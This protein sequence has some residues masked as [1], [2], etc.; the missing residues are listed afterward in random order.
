M[1]IRSCLKLLVI[2][3]F[4]FFL[5]V[6]K[7]NNFYPVFA[8]SCSDEVVVDAMTCELSIDYNGEKYCDIKTVQSGVKLKC[9]QSSCKTTA[10]ICSSNDVG[11]C[12]V[13]NGCNAFPCSEASCTPSGGSCPAECRANS[14]GQGYSPSADCG[15]IT[16]QNPNFG[17]KANQACCSANSCPG[18]G[19]GGSGCATKVDCPPGTTRGTEV[20]ENNCVDLAWYCGAGS[21]QVNLGCCKTKEFCVGET[22]W[23]PCPTPANPGKM[24]RQCVEYEERCTADTVVTYAC[25][26]SCTATAPTNNSAEMTSYTTAT[27]TWTAGTGGNNQQLYVGVDSD[28]VVA[29]CPDG[30]LIPPA[31]P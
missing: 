14:C 22:E 3:I 12:T 7:I 28:E 17:C 13:S 29:S 19:G 5:D 11:N 6:G 23:V 20:V 18:G 21:A 9:N 31:L 1:K 16:P 26:P 15:P 24:C 8:Q 25:V 27:I 4:V 30:S 10:K 2:T